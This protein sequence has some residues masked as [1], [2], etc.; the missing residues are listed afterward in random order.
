MFLIEL[1]EK[2]TLLKKLLKINFNINHFN[3]KYIYYNEESGI[4]VE[5]LTEVEYRN[6]RCITV[7]YKKFTNKILKIKSIDL[8][9]HLRVLDGD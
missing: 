7:K 9:N 6:R 5:E 1:E 8:E 4:F 3:R 2:K